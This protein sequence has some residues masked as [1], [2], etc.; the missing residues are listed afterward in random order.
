MP[1]V[2]GM[3]PYYARASQASGLVRIGPDAAPKPRRRPHQPSTVE[4]MRALY[5]TT[6]LPT[7]A[8][9]AE[10]GAH[11][12]TVARR[13]R[14]HGWLRP[15]TGAPEEHYTAAGRRKLRRGAL[16]E[17]LVARAEHLVFQ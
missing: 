9:A 7:R 8:I 17:A 13:A 12:A 2:L 10:V 3:L 6:Q 1:I 5:E 4:R 11:A 14:R 16:A 15:D